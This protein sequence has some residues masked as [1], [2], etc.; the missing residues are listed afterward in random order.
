MRTKEFDSFFDRTS[1]IIERALDSEANILK[2]YFAEAEEEDGELVQ[3]GD[4]IHHQ[5]TFMENEF[6]KR[7]VSSIDW[8]PK[9]PELLLC[10]YSK[11]SEW[12]VNEADGL[13]NIFSLA[14]RSRPEMQLTS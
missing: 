9:V 5:F 12:K 4:K 2:D 10:S 8:S 13:I 1:R 11:S 3:R 7:A 14:M 6:S